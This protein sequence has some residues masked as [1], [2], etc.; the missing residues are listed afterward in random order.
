[1]SILPIVRMCKHTNALR[2]FTRVSKSR[3]S[4]MFRLQGPVSSIKTPDSIQISDHE[5]IVD[6]D[7]GKF[8]QQSPTP[9]C[10]I[11]GQDVVAACDMQPGDQLTYRCEWW[12]GTQWQ[13]PTD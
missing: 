8:M 12:P 3:H 13:Q 1:M 11:M 9:T 6:K 7:L 2:V 10:T 4:T 5:Y